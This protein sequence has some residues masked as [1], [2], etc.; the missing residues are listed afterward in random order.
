MEIRGTEMNPTTFHSI[1]AQ[2]NLKAKT[3][4]IGGLAALRAK[5]K[6]KARLPQDVFPKSTTF[7]TYAFHYGGRKELQF[8]IGMDND[9]LR[10][11][12]AFSLK[13]N[14][15]LPSIDILTPKIK[16]FNDFMD[17]YAEKFADMRMWYHDGSTRSGD[18]MPTP[19]HTDLV[20]EGVF[21]F[22]GK[23]QT[24]SRINC[25]LILDDLDRLLPLYRYVESEG[26]THPT[27]ALMSGTFQFHPGFTPKAVTA[28]VTQTQKDI[29]VFLRHNALQEALYRK[30]AKEHGRAN[31]S[32]EQPSGVG[33]S[34][35]VVV[36]HEGQFWFF[37]IKTADSPRA[38]LRQAVGQ[39]LEYSFWPGAQFARRLVVVGEKTLD[40]EG[41][42][43]LKTLKS[44][45]RLPFAYE[46]LALE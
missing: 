29:D 14:Q 1:V 21:I 15:T 6:G 39:L 33:T 31:V 3:H 22:L 5:I 38:C 23:H 26:T 12:V 36:R 24:V 40:A 27:T 19:V 8:N 46:Q 34:I 37:E 28:T 43:Y 25:D 2:V 42:K 44:R 18:F 20:H 4:A 41:K 32:V 11:G 16:L 7:D 35:D 9:E 45:F 30:L 17:L 13:T 10:H